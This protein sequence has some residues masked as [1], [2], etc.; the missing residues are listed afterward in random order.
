MRRLMTNPF[1]SIVPLIGDYDVNVVL[2]A[3]KLRKCRVS[4]HVVFNPKVRCAVREWYFGICRY[5]RSTGC[6]SENHRC[7]S[8]TLFRSKAKGFT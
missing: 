1:K 3:L 2:E 6:A 7:A 5:L 8:C 4:L